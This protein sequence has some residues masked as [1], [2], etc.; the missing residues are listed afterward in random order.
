MSENYQDK[1]FF[2]LKMVERIDTGCWEQGR[3]LNDR[4]DQESILSLSLSAYVHVF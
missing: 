4:W 2:K 3:K 1:V